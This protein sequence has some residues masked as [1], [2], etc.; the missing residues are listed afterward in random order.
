MTP[1]GLRPWE[2]DIDALLADRVAFD[3]FIYTPLQEAVEQIE[4]RDKDSDL[5]E[6]VENSLSNTGIPEVMRNKKS[7][8]LFRHIATSN[9]E[10]N[11]FAMC[12]DILEA[13]Q[14]LILE[15]TEDKF[16]DR[17]EGKYFLGKL[18]FHKGVNKMGEPI[19][20][21]SNIINFNESNNKP[22]SSILTHWGQPLVEFHH[23]LFAKNFPQ[24]KNSPHDLSGWLHAV[25]PSAR[26]YYKAFFTLFVRDGILFENF[27]MD[28]KEH[29]FTREIILPAFIE[30][31]SQIGVKPLIVTL[32]PTHMEGDQFWFSHP[33]FMK[34]HVNNKLNS[35]K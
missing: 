18:R 19:Y 34:E 9:Y 17:N 1:N 29:S 16:N 20:E 5:Q 12:A 25:G 10:I 22:I 23:E 21:H 4:K 30:I 2:V 15:Y 8:V 28:G 35:G 3:D 6:Y 31:W 11:R 27:L 26:E 14:P 24:L 7:I 13:F 33:H 32:E